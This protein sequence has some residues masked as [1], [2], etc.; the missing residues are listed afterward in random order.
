MLKGKRLMITGGTGA[1]GAA[2]VRAAAR[3]GADVCFTYHTRA[4]EAE[5]LRAEVVALGRRCFC[6]AVDGN[7]SAGVTRF[8]AQADEAMGPPDV[9]VNNLAVIQVMP[10][11]LIDEADWD[12]VITTNLKGMFL[13]TKAVARGMVHRKRGVIINMGSIAGHRLVE[14]P[15]HY[16][17]TKAAVT[18]FTTSLAKELCRYNIRVNAV[19]PGLIEGGIGYNIS[20][21]QREEYNRY[22]A[23]GRPGKPEEVAE[24]VTFLASDRAAYINGQ[25]VVA[26]GGL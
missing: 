26:D 14:V 5:A 2:T 1:I 7:D 20:D 12:S 22:C 18:G 17:T 10:F 16:A 24:L 6:A 8:V 13:F 3:Y 19:A 4:S 11:A 23:A 25:S 15:V 9:L 21:R